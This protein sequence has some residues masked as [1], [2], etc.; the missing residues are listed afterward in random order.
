MSGHSKWHNIRLKKGKMDAERGKV[1]T[2][3]SREII[4]AARA[5]GGN[6]DGNLRLKMAIQ[7]ARDNSMPA[8]KIKSAILRGTGEVEGA[9]Y[10]E[11]TYEGYGPSGIAVL[12]E[13]ATDNRN[14]TVAELRNIFSK[15]GGNLGESG[16]VGWLFNPRGLV[17]VAKNG[18]TEDDVM[19][20]AIEAGADDVKTEEETFD[21]YTSPDEFAAVRDGLEGAGFKVTSSEVT[22]IPSTTVQITETKVA[23]QMLRMMDQLEDHDDVQN[24]YAN[25]DIEEKILATLV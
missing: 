6:P 16:C 19:E 15:C 13:C 10:E 22:M 25:F 12:V 4:M 21:V 17:S 3:L 20:A 18:R 11:L 5:G 8:D 2:K 9:I 7:K 14:R 23:T 1:F 24:V